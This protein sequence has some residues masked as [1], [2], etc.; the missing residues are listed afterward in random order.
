MTPADQEPATRVV[1]LGPNLE[2]RRQLRQRL[3]VCGIDVVGES[4]IAAFSRSLAQGTDVL[5]VCLDG[6]DDAELDELDRVSGERNEPMVFFESATPDDRTLAR[7]SEKLRAAADESRHAGQ[8]VP[9][10][11]VPA[12]EPESN[13]ELPVWVLG[14]SFGGPQALTE[15][16]G[17]LPTP[18][19]AALIV[20]QHIGDDFA[21]VLAQQLHRAT[22]LNVTCA[23]PRMPLHAG[24][25]YV[26]PIRSRLAIDTA[27]RFELYGDHR[28]DSLYTPNIDEIMATVAARYGH[29]SG[30]IIFSGM[31]SDGAE[32]A[33]AIHRA[34]GCVWAQDEASSTMASMPETASATGTVSLRAPPVELA[35]RLPEHVDALINRHRPEQTA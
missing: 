25:V 21:E 27:G 20:A 33:R 22:Q 9:P 34:G 30:G 8:A 23:A 13:E 5:L 17:N 14:A 18:P 29:L 26:A 24:R 6:A 7:L 11:T 19:A 4:S 28:T 3:T 2:L 32:G 10:P 12:V 1:V 31:A 15:F 16:L 35:A